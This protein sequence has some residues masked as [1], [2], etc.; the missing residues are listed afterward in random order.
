LCLYWCG[1]QGKKTLQT[2]EMYSV[3]NDY[4][5]RTDLYSK[6]ACGFA[7]SLPRASNGG[8]RTSQ[9]ATR[10]SLQL[11]V[12]GV[13]SGSSPLN[14]WIKSA[15]SM[16]PAAAVAMTAPADSQIP[17]PYCRLYMLPKPDNQSGG[18]PRLVA[19]CSLHM[20]SGSLDAGEAGMRKG[21]SL[22]TTE[23]C[24]TRSITCSPCHSAQY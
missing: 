16:M 1:P 23:S 24:L 17:A 6:Y 9:P 8:F 5:N 10:T 4:Q 21:E 18:R 7:L 19:L 11:P 15:E 12:P 20:H 14:G 22:A 3:A 2:R 13:F